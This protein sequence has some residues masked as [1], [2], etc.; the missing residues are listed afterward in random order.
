MW[1]K[2]PDRGVLRQALGFTETDMTVLT[3]DSLAD[4]HL[5]GRRAASGGR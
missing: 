4:R 1:P 5:T 3:F 2:Q